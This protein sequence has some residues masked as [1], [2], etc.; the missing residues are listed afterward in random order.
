[1]RDALAGSEPFGVYLAEAQVAVAR[2]IT[3]GVLFAYLCDVYVD[4][5]HRGRGLGRWLV[6]ALRDHYA[7]RGLNRLLLVTKDAQAL[8]AREGFTAVE[9]GRWMEL[10][11]RR[12]RRLAE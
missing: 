1:M 9:P 5:E 6:R 8:Y 10:D 7:E 2:V 3:D 11:L 12:D 4:R